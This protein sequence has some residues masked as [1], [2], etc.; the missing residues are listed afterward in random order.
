MTRPTPEQRDTLAA[1]IGRREWTKTR[2]DIERATLVLEHAKQAS[3]D[4]GLV[5]P[6]QLSLVMQPMP[7]DA[8]DIRDYAEMACELAAVLKA[9]P[10]SVNADLLALARKYASECGECAGAGTR[11]I[12]TYPG[13]IE[14]DNDDQPCPDCADIRSVIAKATQVRA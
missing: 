7:A 9:L 3:I 5:T 12:T 4:T 6:A 10:Q 13:G 14:V 2:S 8:R 11:T 1:A